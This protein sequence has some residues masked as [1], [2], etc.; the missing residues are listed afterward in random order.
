M[1]PHYAKSSQ[2]SGEKIYI[3]QEEYRTKIEAARAQLNALVKEQKDKISAVLTEE[4]IKKLEDFQT[5]AKA[6]KGTEKTD[7]QKAD[8]TSP[9]VDPCNKYKHK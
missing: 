4:Q 1:P 5:P 2:R 6:K 9:L 8:N 3:I 7:A